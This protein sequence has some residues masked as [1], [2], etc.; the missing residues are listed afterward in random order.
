MP[1]N[2]QR[3]WRNLDALAALTEPDTPWTRRSFRFSPW[4][5]RNAKPL[6][7]GKAAGASVHAPQAQGHAGSDP[8]SLGSRGRPFVQ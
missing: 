6:E 3:L 4:R 8:P 1:V 7:R 5:F 2:G